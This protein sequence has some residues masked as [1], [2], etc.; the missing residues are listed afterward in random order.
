M[1]DS[2]RS[3][4]AANVGQ[5]S[6]AIEANDDTAGKSAVIG[7]ATLLFYELDRIADALEVIAARK[8]VVVPLSEMRF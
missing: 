1:S 8:P 6:K 7:L 3:A 5:L 4:F 2:Q